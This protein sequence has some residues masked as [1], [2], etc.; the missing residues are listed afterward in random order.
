MAEVLPRL[1]RP[2]ALAFL[3][4]AALVVVL[5]WALEGVDW[6]AERLLAAPPRLAD[7]LAR[8]WPP[9]TGHLDRLAWKMVETLQIALAGAALGIVL[10]IPV[11]LLA[12]RGVLAGPATNGAVRMV[13]GFIRAVPD[14]VWALVFVVAVG[15]GPFAGML[16]IAVD[17]LGFCGRFF[18]DDMENA[19]DDPAEAL[20]ATGARRLDVAACA[21][22]P[23]ALPAFVSTALFALEKAVRSSTILGLVGAGGI[24][25]EL[26]VG[27]DMFDY[28]TA[29]TVI[30]MIAVVVVA[31]EQVGALLRR[32]IMGGSR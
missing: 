26:K 5:L 17:T 19:D 32:R 20:A 29:L 18:A 3:G 16:A 2:S 11:A 8:A 9:A 12:A 6:S 13:L 10:S 4:H 24:G 25:I 27:F 28:P 7:F 21:T 31:V 23:A 22:I 15:L 14:L 30:L 1:S